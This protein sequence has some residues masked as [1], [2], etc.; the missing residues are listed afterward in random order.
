SPGQDRTMESQHQYFFELIREH[1]G[2]DMPRLIYADWLD[3]QGDPR[4]EFIRI[5]CELANVPCRDTA[6]VDMGRVIKLENREQ[7]LLKKYN[8]VWTKAFDTF[9]VQKTDFH[10]GF[11]SKVNLRSQ[12]PS[13]EA[14]STFVENWKSLIEQEPALE[15]VELHLNQDW[16]DIQPL[17]RAPQIKAL[18]FNYQALALTEVSILLR[19]PI[20][21]GLTILDLSNNNLRSGVE[22]V[23]NASVFGGLVSLNLSFNSIGTQGA[24]ALASSPNLRGIRS[25]DL[26]GNHIGRGGKKMLRE[27]FGPRV[28]L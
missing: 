8:K 12:R 24:R 5:Q 2:D 15:C 22:C 16:K 26:R 27:A 28:R 14:S 20:V 13:L 1:P 7:D 4:G 3:E 10:R 18:H 25:I 6:R 9:Q 19:W 21:R 23:G 17:Q 11:L